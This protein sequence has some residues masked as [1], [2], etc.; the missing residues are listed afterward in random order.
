[1]P[2]ITEYSLQQL[3]AERQSA[4]PGRFCIGLDPII[5]KT[6]ACIRGPSPGIRVA[7][8][9]MGI[10][11]ATHDS[12]AAFKPQRA[13]WEGLPGGVEGLRM[14]IAYIHTRYPDIPVILDAKR[15]D[16]DRT[17]AMY[18]FAHFVLDEVDA[19]NFNPYMGRDCLEQLIGA[20]ASGHRGLIT[21]GRTSN[22]GA[23]E[24]QDA[25][26]KNGMRVWEYALERAYFWAVMNG[27]VNR[28]GAVMGA[29]HDTSQ[30]DKYKGTIAEQPYAQGEKIFDWHLRRGR[31]IIG[32]S[33]YLVPGLGKQKG[34]TAA[35]LHAAWRGPGT[36]LLSSS[37]AMTQASMGDDYLAAA[38]KA[39]RKQ[40]DEN[41]K[42]IAEIDTPQVSSRPVIKGGPSHDRFNEKYRK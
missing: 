8:H 9:M 4:K 2:G 18:G 15:G 28:F 17:Q 23:W 12:A 24:I 11:D 5:E 40:F 25:C 26:L 3:V 37:S 42:I 30:L 33:L 14:L 38:E 39:A 29:A 6:P 27:V 34:H 31:E 22:P 1:M 35:T 10:V 36:V 32:D 7:I 21:L 13:H 20:D 41:S 19:L 16:I